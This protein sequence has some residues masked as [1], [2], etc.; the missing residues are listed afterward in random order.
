MPPGVRVET[1][2]GKRRSRLRRNPRKPQLPADFP[3]RLR[4]H[5]DLGRLLP[6]LQHLL[7]HGRPAGQ[8]VRHAAHARCLAPPDPH[9][10]RRRGAG[11]RPARR[12]RRDRRR[13]RHRQAAQPPAGSLRNRPADH[14]PGDGVAH[15]RRLAVDRHLRHH[16]LLAGAGAALDAGAADRRPARVRSDAE[17]PPA[18]ARPRALVA[19]RRSVG[20][21]TG[22]D[23]PLRQRRGGDRGRPDRRRCGRDRLRGLTLQ[24]APCA[25]AGGDRRL[26]AGAPAPADSAGSRARTPSA[27]PAAPPSPRRR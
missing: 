22:P 7:D 8:R 14:R 3:A 1:A 15:D 10:G 13:L 23:R 19:A 17:P 9:H 18:P 27:I 6:D 24:P 26:A 20:L 4:L 21:A 5:R 16:A 12:D 2:A 11:D 25:T